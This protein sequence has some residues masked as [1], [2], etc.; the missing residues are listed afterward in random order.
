MRKLH[1]LMPTILVAS[2]IPMVSMIGCGKKED[3]DYEVD[4]NLMDEETGTGILFSKPTSF[5]PNKTYKFNFA[6]NLVDDNFFEKPKFFAFTTMYKF[7]TF[8]S[9][10]NIKVIFDGR[11]LNLIDDYKHVTDQ[12][13]A[14]Y[15]EGVTVPWSI[16]TCAPSR[17][18]TDF[19][20]Y[21]TFTKELDDVIV[22]LDGD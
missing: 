4:V 9:V 20:I 14:I 16:F 18:N 3:Y 12:N 5:L 6:T 19:N 21:L 15:I 8:P 1:I 10:A 11:E 7:I 13:Y 22:V 17:K 2:S